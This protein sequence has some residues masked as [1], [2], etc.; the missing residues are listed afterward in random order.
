MNERTCLEISVQ[1]ILPNESPARFEP[2]EA[3]AACGCAE[4]ARAHGLRIRS[5]KEV[6]FHAAGL[7]GPDENAYEQTL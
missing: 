7:C 6:R 5:G 4:C 2:I 1:A 3:R